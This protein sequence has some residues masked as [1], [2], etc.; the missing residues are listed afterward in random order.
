MDGE[1]PLVFE[2]L[3]FRQFCSDY[4]T[5]RKKWDDGFTHSYICF[6]LG[7]RNSR[8]LFNNI[9]KGRKKISQTFI[10]RLIELF[11]LDSEESH[12]FSVLVSYNQAENI[13][14]KELYFEQ[15]V[16]LSVLPRQQISEENYHYYDK[17]Y[18]ATIR[19]FLDIYDFVDDY[20][21]LAERLYPPISEEEAKDSITLLLDMGLIKRNSEGFFKPETKAVTTGLKANHHQVKRYQL[22]NLDLAKLAIMDEDLTSYKST[23][24]T[25]SISKSG[26]EQIIERMTRFQ[27]EICTIVNNDTEKAEELYQLS[28][29]VFPQSK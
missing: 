1:L 9:I 4:Y 6:R 12:Y 15:L 20:S 16:K 19:A 17:W 27:K 3:S 2:Y 10:E 22:Q 8:T 21:A 14:E 11:E 18:H 28:L 5:A 24:L 29:N 13:A 7:Q 25:I 26:Y 23:T